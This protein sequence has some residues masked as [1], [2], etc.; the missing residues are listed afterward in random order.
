MNFHFV[1]NTTYAYATPAEACQN[2]LHLTPRSMPGQECLELKL[3][4]EPV[5]ASVHTHVDFFGNQVH[6]FALLEPHERLSITS[7]GRVRVE[8]ELRSLALSPPWEEVRRRLHTDR[9]DT[10][11][12]ALQYAYDSPYI[13][14]GETLR[15]FAASS[16][17]P[18]RPL[19][20]ATLDFTKRIHETFT[21]DPTATTIDTSPD[22][23]LRRRRGV[24]QDF[25]HLQIA[26]LR[27]LGLSARY[28][29]GYLRTESQGSEPRWTGAD[30]SH[31]WLS[32][33]CPGQGWVDFDPTNGC[34]VGND[35]ITLAW[36]RDYHDVS[37]VKGIVLGSTRSGMTVAVAVSED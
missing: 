31:A 37:P 32:A 29:S 10:T 6:H 13:R 24:C 27:S 36:G 20:A 1:H 11:I 33:F 34:L 17:S 16:F 28:V 15:E 8:R 25:A 21:Y 19:L 18:G 26:C 9:D 7:E 12:G 2:S 23:V 3:R 5:P 35:H 22:D 4:I 30:A 14:A